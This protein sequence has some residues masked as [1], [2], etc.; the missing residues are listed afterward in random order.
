MI[1]YYNFNH[2]YYDIFVIFMFELISLFIAEIIASVPTE[3]IMACFITVL[4]FK[5]HFMRFLEQ[6]ENSF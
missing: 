4:F 2:F 6:F 3:A 1:I 5:K